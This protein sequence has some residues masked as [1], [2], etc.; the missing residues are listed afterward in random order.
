MGKLIDFD[1]FRAERVQEPVILRIGGEDYNLPS[2][3]P[4]SVAIDVIHLQ[5]QVKSD[6]EEVP[7]EALDAVGR[8]VFGPAVWEDVLMK[9]RVGMDEMVDLIKMVLAAYSPVAEDDADPQVASTPE[10]SEPSSVS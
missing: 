3:L 8:S 7:F 6:E 5:K 4:A 9:H 1:A 2:S 10:M